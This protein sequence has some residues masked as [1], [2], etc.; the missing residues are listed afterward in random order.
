[1]KYFILFIMLLISMVN[2]Q[3]MC[4]KSWDSCDGAF[5]KYDKSEHLI[6]SA[7]LYQGFRTYNWEPKK[8]LLYSVLSGFLWEV[9]DSLISY[10][11][12]GRMGGDGFDYKDFLADCAGIFLSYEL[13]KIHINITFRLYLEK[14][15]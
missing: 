15:I 1:M 9:K 5:F 12:F 8:R 3:V 11:D 2:A 4:K 13:E 10:K 6:G 14:E 7:I